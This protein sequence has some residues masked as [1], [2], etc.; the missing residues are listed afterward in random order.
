MTPILP[1][2]A[3]PL[4]QEE[5]VWSGSPSMALLA[6]R[7][8]GLIVSAV[9][10]PLLAYFIAGL[11]EDGEQGG[12]LVIAGWFIAAALVLLFGISIVAGMVLLRST[13]YTITNQ[14]LL[15]ESGLF[16]KSVNEIDMRLIDD[17]RFHQGFIQRMLGIGNV[18]VE[19]SDKNAPVFTMRGVR[20]PRAVREVIRTHAFAASQRQVF[21]RPT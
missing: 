12:G 4:A 18:T 8:A 14:R 16:S 21:T 11:T 20:D 13:R 9:A 1:T 5:T 6:G 3:P 2:S 19:S 17:S 15:I 7:I 10:I